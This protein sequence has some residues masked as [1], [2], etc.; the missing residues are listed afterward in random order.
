MQHEVSGTLSSATQWESA[1]RS[2]IKPELVGKIIAQHCGNRG[3][4]MSVL[5][6]LQEKYGHLPR[7]ALEIVAL[8]MGR[9]LV[10]L[11]G[12]A[13]FYKSFSLQPRGK[14]LVTVC[15][16]TACHV[17]HS[18][19]VVTEFE[20]RLG[21]RAGETTEDR[22]F[23]LETVNCLGACALG[24][25]AVVDGHY[26]T[27]VGVSGVEAIIEKAKK[28]LDRVSLDDPDR[29]FPVGVSCPRCN[30]SLMDPTREIDGYPSIRVTAS[31]GRRHG[32]L[33]IS[34][35]YGSYR[36]ESK[37]DL[38]HDTLVNFFCPHCHQELIGALNCP[39]CGVRMV[40]MIVRGGGTVHICPRR[41]CR[42]HVLD[43]G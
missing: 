2:E 33:H 14:H 4:V 40:P 28:G 6:D 13:T 8:E 5:E 31:F 18:P 1:P 22:S 29:T 20:K 26:F 36:I 27:K 34:S 35:L 37:H 42:G 15:M 24:P 17:R 21:I 12:V 43:V 9:D 38:P 25:V 19:L 11:Y 39:E 30:H 16:G 7:Q 23:T 41:G 3:D 10:D 32:W